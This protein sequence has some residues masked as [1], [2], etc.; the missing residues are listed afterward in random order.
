MISAAQIQMIRNAD[1]GAVLPG[2]D[3]IT[4]DP[5]APSTLLDVTK[6][7]QSS[8]AP[9]FYSP[10]KNVVYV[11]Q[12][13]AVLN[14]INFGSATVIIDANNVTIKDC[15]FT[16]TSSYW[17]VYQTPAYSGA[18]VQ[19][20]TFQGS[21]SPTETNDWISSTQAITITDNK[22]LNSPTDAIDICS[23]VVSGN[24]FSGA[25]YATGAHSDAIWV[26]DSN[27]PTTITDNLIDG[28]QNVDAAGPANSDIRLTN[29][30]GNLND[31]TVS[32]NYLI[33]AGYTVEVAAANNPYTISN[34]SIANNYIGF[35]SYGAYFP[36]TA[37]LATITGNTIVDFTNSS[38]STQAMTAYVAAGVPT[39]NV[40]SATSAANSVASGSSPTTILGN[41]F[42]LAHLFANAGET[43]F[44]GGFGSQFLMGGQG[45]NIFTYLS[46]GDGGDQVSAFD[47]AKDVIDLSHIDGDLSTPGVQNFTFIG[48]APFSGFGAQVRYQ[49]DPT[50]DVTYVQADLAGD[51][52]NFTPDFTITLAGLVP[53]TAANFAL[54]P[55]QSSAALA[56]GAALTYSAVQTVAGAP[57]EYAYSNVL[58]RTYK[59]YESFYGSGYE[60]L[61]A[62]DLNLNSTTNKLILYNPGL[63]VTKSA[64]S[65][66][67][68]VAGMGTDP[69]AYH[70]V[71]TI[72]ATTSGGEQFIF[73]AGFGRETITGFAASGASPDA[74]QLAKSSFSYLTAGMTQAQDLASVL[75]HSVGGSWGL[76]IPNSFNDY[77]TLAG[78][79]AATIAANPAAIQFV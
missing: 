58:G 14:G 39:T 63:T 16:G 33:G 71:E 44:V 26:T 51:A 36:T 64:R 24:Y 60:N 72:D 18:T 37:G 30:M 69:L 46:V 10:S 56:D 76:T 15:T 78:V 41:G 20:C 79:S 52:G 21:K 67:L 13:G 55:S 54:T 4:G 70:A 17:A 50:K 35:A 47:P 53:L 25:A 22:F 57:T 42:A 19:N 40:V 38:P 9:Y 27:G 75:A 32:G 6:I 48:S 11:N 28:T 2:I 73:G 61:A 77:L 3:T 74:I 5:L 29:E 62:D 43:N 66:T 12:N 45:A 23:G 34:V 49:L 7:T 65:E 59:S 68:Q 1:P 8:K 31:V